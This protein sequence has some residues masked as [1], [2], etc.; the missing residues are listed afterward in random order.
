MVYSLSYQ[1][2]KYEHGLTAAEQRAADVRAG[3]VAAA[4]RNLR[5]SLGRAL[6]PRHRVLPPAG[7]RTRCREAGPPHRRGSCRVFGKGGTMQYM[8]LHTGAPDLDGAWDDKAWAALSSW[9]E[10]TIA[11]RG[12]HRGARCGW[13]RTL[14]PSRSATASSSSPTGPM[15]RPRSRWP[16]TT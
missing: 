16:A 5:L 1:M 14:P 9:I 8:L 6:R 4:L 13:T 2:Y 10:E 11:L 3:E 7:R 12:Q 15:R